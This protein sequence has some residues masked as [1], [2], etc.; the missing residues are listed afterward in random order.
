M[1]PSG[2][3]APPLRMRVLGDRSSF[4]IE[5]VQ[6][7]DIH[8]RVE[9]SR[10]YDFTVAAEGKKIA[11]PLQGW[12]LYTTRTIQQSEF[13]NGVN[14]GNEQ[15]HVP[16]DFWSGKVRYDHEPT[17]LYGTVGF[18]AKDSEFATADNKYTSPGYTTFN[19]RVGWRKDF[20]RSEKRTILLDLAVSVEN[21][22]DRE[23][24]RR[25]NATQYVP[26]APRTLFFEFG[27]TVEF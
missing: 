12:S 14:K 24:Y 3:P 15:P 16:G 2:G 10:G 23:F 22:T 13:T 17:G 21:L 27:I 1:R 6:L 19:G 11:E 26:G 25:H 20:S 8:Y 7:L 9:E 18:R 5:K 4:T